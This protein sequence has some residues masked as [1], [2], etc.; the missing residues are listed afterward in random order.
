MKT[1]ISYLICAVAIILVTVGVV[2]V[3]AREINV[4]TIFPPQEA[5]VKFDI[6]EKITEGI[7]LLKSSPALQYET[8]DGRNESELKRRQIALAILDT[9]SGKLQEVRVWAKESELESDQA[10]PFPIIV[11]WWNSFNSTYQI[12]N[13]P[14][15][16]VVANKY[17]IP[18]SYLPEQSIL[19][20]V[21]DAPQSRYMDMVYVPYSKALHA[22]DVVSAGKE[23]INERVEEAYEA[24][25]RL[26]VPSR[27]RPGALVADVISQDLVKNIVLVEH[28]DPTWLELADD[29]GKALAER[30]LIL[31]GANRE[32]AYRYTNSK[33]DAYGLG[34]FIEPT[35]NAMVERYPTANLITDRILGMADHTNA[36]KAMAILFDNEMAEIQTK[37]GVPATDEMLSAAYNG[38]PGR[39][40]RAVKEHGQAWAESEIFP[41]ETSSYVKKYDMIKK[42]EIFNGIL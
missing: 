8:I 32:W 38:G 23:Y 36:F 14:N 40:I 17:L 9:K 33:A 15:L 27:A 34:Q 21:A 1:W 5:E 11:Q 18:R 25:W 10:M 35:Y 29:G 12:P 22:P 26:Q 16:I 7:A 13:H 3:Q 41:S 42:L 19:E 31:I 2:F 6:Y 28:I 37:A 30:V 39:V 24:L 4:A 20:L